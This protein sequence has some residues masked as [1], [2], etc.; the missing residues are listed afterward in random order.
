VLSW[1]KL[2]IGIA[3]NAKIG[4]AGAHGALVYL[5]GLCLHAQHGVGG[6][7]PGHCMTA[8]ALRI[9]AAALMLDLRPK[10]IEVAIDRCI[11]A[12]LL[13]RDGDTFVLVDFDA[14]RDSPRCSRCHGPN[15]EPRHATC[16]R[17]R[18]T[19]RVG[20]DDSQP[21][22]SDNGSD[23]SATVQR[24]VV[25]GQ[26]RIGQN[27]TGPGP[28]GRDQTRPDQRGS[29]G[30]NGHAPESPGAPLPGSGSAGRVPEAFSVGNE[31]HGFLQNIT[32]WRE[33]ARDRLT[34][35]LKMSGRLEREGM[36]VAD[37]RCLWDWARRNA[38]DPGDPGGYFDSLIGSEVS[39][40]SA[41]P[42]ARAR[43][44]VP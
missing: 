16:P 15:I 13:A 43:K 14:E 9:E 39:W 19:R 42:Q 23:R 44:V 25:A 21:S 35:C 40:R 10:Q 12:G 41:L 38:K 26:D 11:A 31:L 34:Q 4:A 33:R 22:V 36:T 3:S 6:R 37:L 18:A 27:P 5:A 1:I 2:D 24:P 28:D 30:R 20:G 8:S 7:I 32:T 29:D 17:C